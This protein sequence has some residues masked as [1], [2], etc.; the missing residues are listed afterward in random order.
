[1]IGFASFF[2]GYLEMFRVLD[3]HERHHDCSLVVC[4][5][6]HPVAGEEADVAVL[7]AELLMEC[8]ARGLHSLA[9]VK[10]AVQDEVHD[11]LWPF[12]CRRRSKADIRAIEYGAHPDL[13]ISGP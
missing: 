10:A 4:L 5:A 6:I 12:A 9:T 1:M 3:L 8:D 2:D 7:F 13:H 11:F